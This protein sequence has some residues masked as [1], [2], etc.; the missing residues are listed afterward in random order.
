MIRWTRRGWL[1]I[2][3]RQGGPDPERLGWTCRPCV[4]SLW[5]NPDW[6]ISVPTHPLL[7]WIRLVRP[8]DIVWILLFAALVATLPAEYMDVFGVG[9]LVALGLVQVLEP[10]V[11]EL[12]STRSRVFWILL[13]MILGFVL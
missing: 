13:K 4:I 3:S 12:A 6:D 10:K 1:G 11:P 5:H 8:Q 2:R 7:R 9:P